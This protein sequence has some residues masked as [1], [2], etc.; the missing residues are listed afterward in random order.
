MWL[1]GTPGSFNCK[2]RGLTDVIRP[3]PEQK[4]DDR[5]LRDPDPLV[6][7]NLAMAC[8]SVLLGEKNPQLIARLRDSAAITISGEQIN[9]NPPQL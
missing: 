2:E 9:P 6:G 8:M 3:N 4:P 1:A 7:A 5:A